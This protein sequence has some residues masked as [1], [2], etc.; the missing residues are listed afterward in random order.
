MKRY[1]ISM[2]L[3]L[4]L[5]SCAT[6]PAGWVPQF[7]SSNTIVLRPGQSIILAKGQTAKVPFGTAVHMVNGGSVTLMGHMNTINAAGGVIVSVPVDAT[8][9]ADN[10]VLTNGGAPQKPNQPPEPTGM[11]VTPR[12]DAR[13]APAT[14]VAHL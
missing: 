7:D 8:G 3:L 13:V 5:S 6:Q 4:G 11:S 1:A 10:V 12:A 9:P 14:P 2:A